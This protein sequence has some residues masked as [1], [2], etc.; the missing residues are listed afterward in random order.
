MKMKLALRAFLLPITLYQVAEK[1]GSHVFSF[2]VNTWLYA[3]MRRMIAHDMRAWI[4]PS[5]LVM[6]C[7]SGSGAG[8]F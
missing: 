8:Y 2:M 5:V 1:K 6:I 3:D 7:L 4:R